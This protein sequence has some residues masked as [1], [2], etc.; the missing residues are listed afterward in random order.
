[1]L[2]NK[3]IRPLILVENEYYL[4]TN[5]PI[6]EDD[7]YL[8]LYG[9]K[10]HLIQA[11]NFIGFD[12]T[13]KNQCFKV[14]AS[15]QRLEGCDLINMVALNSLINVEVS[16][17]DIIDERNTPNR[18]DSF[19]GQYFYSEQD[20]KDIVDDYDNKQMVREN[21]KHRIQWDVEIEML[22]SFVMGGGL[23]PMGEIGGKGNTRYETHSPRIV[24]GF[25]NILKLT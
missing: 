15:T 21:I 11:K 8:W 16:L 10:Y 20:I 7:W 25:I 18:Y 4:L 23:L 17:Q 24:N 14:T 2:R 5:E 3:E 12:D 19:Y 9:G 1:M 6:K 22:T 13:V